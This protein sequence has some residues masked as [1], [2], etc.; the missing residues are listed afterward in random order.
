[1]LHVSHV[2]PYLGCFLL[3]GRHFKRHTVC[4]NFCQMTQCYVIP[5]LFQP[6]STAWHRG[7]H[8]LQETCHYVTAG[9]ILCL[10]WNHCEALPQSSSL[11]LKLCFFIWRQVL[12]LTIYRKYNRVKG[13]LLIHAAT[14]FIEMRTCRGPQYFQEINL[15]ALLAYFVG[16]MAVMIPQ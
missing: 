10:P 4:H 12:N 9:D 1:M 13:R 14:L 2:F 8:R 11:C 3:Q 6:E 15:M 16:A 7:G 5:V